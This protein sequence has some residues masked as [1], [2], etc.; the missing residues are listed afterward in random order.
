M[1]KN[2]IFEVG[3]RNSS[4]GVRPVSVFSDA[5]SLLD[6]SSDC[7]SHGCA[8]E[9]QMYQAVWSMWPL[10]ERLRK[11]LTK[12]RNAEC[13]KAL[14]REYCGS[15]GKTCGARSVCGIPG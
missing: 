11:I 15:A 7:S 12:K 2:R 3:Q 13:Y 4:A 9:W 6:L 8:A 14:C 5:A 10:I 1:G